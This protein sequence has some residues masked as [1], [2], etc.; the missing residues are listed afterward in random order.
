MHWVI[1]RAGTGAR[2]AQGATAVVNISGRFL[3][4][5]YFA[6]TDLTGGSE[7]LPV[8]TGMLIPGLDEAILDMSVGEI[9]TVIL[10]P[11]L[12]YGDQGV[13]DLIPPNSFLVFVIELV[14]VL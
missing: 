8:G 14:S 4:G 6:N 13:G 10:P 3:D 7:E 1:G 11:E 5:R 2:P 9:R 12:A